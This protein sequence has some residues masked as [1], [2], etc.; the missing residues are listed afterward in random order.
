MGQDG[1]SA[2]LDQPWTRTLPARAAREVIICGVFGSL[3]RWYARRDVTGHEHL[4]AV[5]GPVIF[6]ANHCSHVDTPALL[7]SLPGPYR[8]RTA[9][10][11]AADYFYSKQLLAHA[12]SL[13]FCTIPLERRGGGMG[14][15]A[16]AHM[17]RL[18][19]DRWSLVVF[20]EGTRS[21]DGRVGRLRSGAAVLAAEYGLPIVPVHIAGTHTAMP[22]GSGWMNRPQDGGRLARHTIP[23]TFGKPIPGTKDDDRFE[24]M[25]QVRLHMAACGAD[26]TQHPKPARRRAAAQAKATKVTAA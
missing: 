5:D 15:D 9:V 12:V 23:V 17:K 10:A 4:D 22:T 11:A 6:V 2:S 7:A 25:E 21:R 20:A 13:S 24:I 1:T 16:T 18:T 26:T 3:I 19:D 14:E 8:R